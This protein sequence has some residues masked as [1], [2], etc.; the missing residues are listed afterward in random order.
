VRLT[1]RDDW[2]LALDPAERREA[3]RRSIQTAAGRIDPLAGW[4]FARDGTLD[5]RTLEGW[6]RERQEV[7]V[8]IGE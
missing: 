6:R 8:S 4:P 7:A 5:A 1:G 3:A 2:P